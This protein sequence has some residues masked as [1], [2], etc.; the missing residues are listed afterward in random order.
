MVEYG[1]IEPFDCDDPVFCLG[2]EWE[3]FRQKLLTTEQPFSVTIHAENSGDF[4][5]VWT[6]KGWI[7]RGPWEAAIITTLTGLIETSR[8]IAKKWL[9]TEAALKLECEAKI[10]KEDQDLITEWSK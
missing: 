1:L 6:P 9:A 10:N 3:Q 4:V 5:T 7:K 8:E 2:V